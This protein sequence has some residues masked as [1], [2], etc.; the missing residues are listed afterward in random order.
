MQQ[1]ELL[2]IPL[3]ALLVWIVGTLFKSEDDKTK[4]GGPGRGNVSGRTPSRRP[5]TNLNR[6]LE[7]ARRRRE[8]DERPKA[9]PAAPP[10]RAPIARPPLR[11]RASKPR[12]APPRVA[13][14]V[15]RREEVPVAV[16][17]ARAVAP[18]P[19]VEPVPTVTPMSDIVIPAA[20]TTTRDTHLSPIVQQVHS[21]L[22]QPRTAATAFVLREIF[23][24]PLC[25]RRR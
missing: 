7:E 25:K 1:W 10:P 4:K 24:R 21:L 5:A 2:I 14:P 23:D 13:P 12:E 11:E 17:A 9:T 3:I 6:F 18:P 19:V 20:P 8:G 15:I 22:S 16:P